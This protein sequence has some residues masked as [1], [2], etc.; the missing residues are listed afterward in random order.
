M[1]DIDQL[2]DN[3][4][5]DVDKSIREATTPTATTVHR[6]AR[7]RTVVLATGSVL[8]V[9]LALTGVIL[10]LRGDGDVAST[11][12]E[13]RITS[14]MIL[15]DGVVTEEEYRAG[16][17]AVV[18]CLTDAGFEAQVDFDGPNPG[19]NSL[20]GHAEFGVDHSDDATE[21]ATD[22][23]DKCQD[24]HLSHNVALGWSAG[25]ARPGRVT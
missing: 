12:G 25:P 6:R 19:T 13:G 21:S 3:A 16:A 10:T 15:E 23:F 2:L 8:V 11:S 22:A 9:G 14:E 24:L 17:I 7:R 18:A 5:S 4:G 20:Q 1:R